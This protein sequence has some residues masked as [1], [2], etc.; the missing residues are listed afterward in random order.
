M[1]SKL[2][3]LNVFT[4]LPYMGLDT[5]KPVFCG[6]WSTKVQTSLHIW[7]LI[8][9]FVIPL[10]KS[11][12]SKLATSVILIFWLV[13]GAEQAGLGMT[14]SETP[15]TG[16]LTFRPISHQIGGNWKLSRVKEHQYMCWRDNIFDSNYYQYAMKNGV[17]KTYI[18]FWQ[19]LTSVSPVC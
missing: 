5:R 12:K 16:F 17:P 2:L 18:S 4:Y 8:S 19:F 1:R 10:L 13:S 11:I 14:F 15:K 7:C 3:Y 9:A 6:L